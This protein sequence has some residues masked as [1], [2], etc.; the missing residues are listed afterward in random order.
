MWV[1]SYFGGLSA[2][3][4]NAQYFTAETRSSQG[5]EYF[6]IKN[7]LL[8]ALRASAVSSLLAREPSRQRSPVSTAADKTQPIKRCGWFLSFP[9]LFS[10]FATLLPYALEQKSRL[11]LRSVI[12]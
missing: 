12:K 1:H 3:N 4:W 10:H 6:L 9:K 8:G 11:K 2:A 5:P 7:S